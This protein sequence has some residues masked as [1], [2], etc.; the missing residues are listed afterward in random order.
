MELIDRS[1][2]TDG[3]IRRGDTTPSY[4]NIA[5][6]A[7][8]GSRDEFYDD[9]DFVVKSGLANG[10]PDAVN[11]GKDEVYEYILDEG[12]NLTP[13]NPREDVESGGEIPRITRVQ[14]FLIFCI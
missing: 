11:D 10:W 4:Y 14:S 3:A 1:Y 7:V 9:V 12:S 6:D 8:N 13:V 2:S 5:L